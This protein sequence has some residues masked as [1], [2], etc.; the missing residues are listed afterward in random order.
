MSDLLLVLVVLVGS[1]ICLFFCVKFGTYA[2]YCGLH[3]ANQSGK[4]LVNGIDERKEKEQDS[5]LYGR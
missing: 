3:L 1:P 5:P 2:Y 4:G